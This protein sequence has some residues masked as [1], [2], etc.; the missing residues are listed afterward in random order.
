VS[1]EVGPGNYIVGII[2][3]A[4]LMLN[5]CAIHRMISYPSARI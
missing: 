3:P 2:T 4:K 1:N 5:S